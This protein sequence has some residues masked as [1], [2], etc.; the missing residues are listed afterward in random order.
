MQALKWIQSH[1]IISILLSMVI[2]LIIG[3]LFD[4]SALRSSVTLLSFLM[5]YPMMI[6]LNFKSLKEKGNIKLQVTTQLIN[7]VFA[8]LLALLFGL[9]FFSSNDNFKLGILLIALL[10]T[11]GMTV[12]WTVMAKGNVKE[13]IR[14]IVIGLILGGL[15]TPIYI[16]LFMNQEAS[17]P[18]LT[19]I[20]QIALIVFL[21]MF[22]GFITQMILINR[23]SLDIF[24]T[25]IKPVIPRFSTFSLVILITLVMSLRARLILS[26]PDILITLIIPIILGYLVMLG[27]IHFVGKKLFNKEDRIALVNGTMIRNLSLALAIALTVFNTEGPEIA[28]IIAVAYIVQVQLAAWYVKNEIKKSTKTATL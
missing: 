15:L 21:P 7:F 27:S 23:Y 28:L 22:L 12:S 14:M 13:A 16:N 25:K 19:I 11:S 10:P 1:L 6:T 3:R 20:S 2:G 8:P 4:T 17:I 24:N 5:V 9:I 18:F 26:Q